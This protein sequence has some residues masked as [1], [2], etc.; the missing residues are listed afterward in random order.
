VPRTWGKKKNAERKP[1]TG[2]KMQTA[3]E[4]R[5]KTKRAR[6]AGRKE[7]ELEKVRE[8]RKKKKKESS[9]HAK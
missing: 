1:D 9:G 6:R 2:W 3:K 4:R 8:I 7:G 5:R